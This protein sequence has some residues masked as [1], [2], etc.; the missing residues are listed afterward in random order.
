MRG[1]S[2]ARRPVLPTERIAHLGMADCC[3]HPPGRNEAIAVTSP[4][5]LSKEVAQN[6]PPTYRTS[7]LPHHQ[8]SFYAK[9]PRMGPG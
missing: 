4:K 2:L 9:F 5:I 8:K 1:G 3:I 6:R 7:N